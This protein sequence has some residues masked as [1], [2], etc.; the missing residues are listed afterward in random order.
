MPHVV[1]YALASEQR[2]R[3]RDPVVCDVLLHRDPEVQIG[4]LVGLAQ[5]ESLQLDPA[6]V[7][8]A[9]EADTFAE[10]HRREVD[11]DLVEQARPRYCRLRIAPRLPLAYERADA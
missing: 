10:E 2:K 4:Q 7:L 5:G 9:V 11:D 8:A 3:D 1:C 6:F